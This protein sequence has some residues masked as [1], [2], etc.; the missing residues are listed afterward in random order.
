MYVVLSLEKFGDSTRN[1]PCHLLI[2]LSIV[3]KTYH[4]QSYKESFMTLTIS[5]SD[6]TKY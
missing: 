6:D 4:K 2:M 3:K 1:R 5:H